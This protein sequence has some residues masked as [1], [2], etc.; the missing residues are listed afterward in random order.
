M[1]IVPDAREQ[2]PRIREDRG[3]ERGSR[4]SAPRH[5]QAR[6]RVSHDRAVL[7]DELLDH[8]VRSGIVSLLERQPGLNKNQVSRRL[9]VH[10]SIMVFHLG[11][12]VEAGLVEILPGSDR[13]ERLCFLAEDAYL[14]EDE[15]TRVLFGR[16]AC[17]YVALYIC[18]NPGTSSA[19]IATAVRRSI[20][21][22]QHHLRTLLGE[23]LIDRMRIG[24][25][26][27]YEAERALS[28]WTRACGDGYR[29]PWEVGTAAGCTGPAE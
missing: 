21:A 11:R 25:K 28:Q 27:L 23:A 20:E 18:E 26:V 19:A 7:E 8:P 10:P 22:V 5:R 15:R 29:R 4:G 16:S 17:R 3:S 9:D 14:W 13:R 24:R 2:S 12:V 6:L 1:E